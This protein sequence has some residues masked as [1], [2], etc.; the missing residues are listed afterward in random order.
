MRVQ[1]TKTRGWETWDTRE[2]KWPVKSEAACRSKLQY[3]VGQIIKNK[4]PLD[5]VLEDV[6]LPRSRLSLD[7]F[8]PMRKLA[9]EVQ[10]KQHKKFTPFFHKTKSSFDAQLKRDEEKEFFCQL[11]EIDLVYIDSED[12]AI[13]RFK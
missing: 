4:Y 6:T 13:K 7:F 12:D 9:V 10:G 1:I 2:S 5:P 11:N 8:L 3:K